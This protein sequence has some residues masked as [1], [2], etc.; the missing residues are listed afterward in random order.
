[1][2]KPKRKAAQTSAK[3]TAKK[4]TKKSAR[5]VTKK[6]SIKKSTAKKVAKKATVK[7]SRAAAKPQ[8]SFNWHDLMTPDVEG[9][10][11]FYGEVVGWGTSQEMPHYTV[12]EVGGMGV[13]G[14]MEMP[15][16]LKG[17]PPFWSGYIAVK[18][19]DKACV[20][21][22]KAGGIVH[23]E[24]WD[25]P[26][27]LRMAVVSDPAGGVFNMYTPVP[28]GAMKHPSAGATGTVGWNELMTSDVEGSAKFYAKQFGWSKGEVHDMGPEYGKYHLLNVKKKNHAG[29]MKRPGSMPRDYWGF[30]FNV[31]GI[32]SAVERIKARGG[33][34]T[35]GPMQVPTGSW[36]VNAQ[37]PQGAHFSLMSKTK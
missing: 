29:M 5:A 36:V 33:K 21:L 34:V 24:P 10:K 37:D 25:I 14:I 13:G 35:N 27:M 3:K 30:Y 16:N 7:K 8:Y 22:K 15:E 32:D 31:H 20:A 18:N 11:H 1:M 12:L 26:D 6:S 2:K 4:A 28:R 9:A 23:R 19:V 17:S